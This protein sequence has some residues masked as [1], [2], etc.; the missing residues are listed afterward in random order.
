MRGSS[1]E[2]GSFNAWQEAVRK[3]QAGKGPRPAMFEAYGRRPWGS[4]GPQRVYK[5]FARAIL[6]VRAFLKE[7]ML[8]LLSTTAERKDK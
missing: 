8:D 3:T 4:E 1:S 5:D 7:W 6:E 2:Y